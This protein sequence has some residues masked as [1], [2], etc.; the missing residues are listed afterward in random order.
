M[1][2]TFFLTFLLFILILFLTSAS[3]S[4][5]RVEFLNHKIEELEDIKRGF[6]SKAV[7]HEEQAQRLQFVQGQLLLAQRHARA[8]EKYEQAAEKVQ[9]EID[10]LDKERRQ[11]I[12]K[13]G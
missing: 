11:L 7:Y 4:E 5:Q 8:A 12:R 10:Q 1:L 13:N 6:E 2:Q 3:S 9:E